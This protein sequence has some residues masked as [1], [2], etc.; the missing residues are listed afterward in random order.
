MGLFAAR[1]AI[2]CSA[3][4]DPIFNIIQ[5]SILHYIRY[6]GEMEINPIFSNYFEIALSENKRTDTARTGA[7]VRFISNCDLTKFSLKLRRLS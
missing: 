1:C 4:I 2:N 6:P 5:F 7:I 3:A